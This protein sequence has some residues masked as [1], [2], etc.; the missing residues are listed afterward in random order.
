MRFVEPFDWALPA[1][2]YRVP[3]RL[4]DE[5]LKVLNRPVPIVR[6]LEDII[7]KGEPDICCMLVAVEDRKLLQELGA[8]S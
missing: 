3:R 2:A 5:E 6:S 4:F 7:C 8:K 1:K